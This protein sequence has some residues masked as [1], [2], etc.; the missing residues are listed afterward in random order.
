MISMNLRQL[1]Y[2]QAIADEGYNISRA[3]IALHTSQPGISKQISL[4]EREFSTSH[5]AC[6]AT[7]II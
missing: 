2:L 3:A 5:N 6:C 7:P 1:R 4:L